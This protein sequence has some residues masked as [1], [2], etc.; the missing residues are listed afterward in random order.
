M[1]IGSP[2]YILHGKLTWN[3][4]NGGLEDDFLFDWVFFRF[5][6][7]FRGCIYIYIISLLVFLKKFSASLLD[8][9]ASLSLRSQGLVEGKE[10]LKADERHLKLKHQNRNL[11]ARLQICPRKTS[12]ET[13]KPQMV[14]KKVGGESISSKFSV[15]LTW[16]MLDS[17]DLWDECQKLEN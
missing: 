5:H 4:K 9:A 10:E 2:L 14:P 8:C 15:E 13:S 7:N 12:S 6:V 17:P 11:V 3:P 1:S 16:L